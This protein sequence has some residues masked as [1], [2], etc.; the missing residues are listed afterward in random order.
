MVFDFNHFQKHDMFLSFH[1]TTFF[2]CKKQMGCQM[3]SFH[4]SLGPSETEPPFFAGRTLKKTRRLQVQIRLVRLR[5][6]GGDVAFVRLFQ[7]NPKGPSTPPKKVFWDGF[8]G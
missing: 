4:F 7:I 1:R 8:G 6:L 2:F 3:N 5:A